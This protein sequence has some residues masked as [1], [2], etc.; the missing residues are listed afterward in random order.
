MV[1]HIEKHEKHDIGKMGITIPIRNPFF[2]N[3]KVM[4]YKKICTP[5]CQGNEIKET[6]QENTALII[7]KSMGWGRPMGRRWTTN[8]HSAPALLEVW[9]K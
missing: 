2:S 3:F 9:G 5:K 4:P 6:A 7:K 8:K 1:D